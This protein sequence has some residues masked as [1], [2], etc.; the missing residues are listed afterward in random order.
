[1]TQNERFL[2]FFTRSKSHYQKRAYQCIKLLVALFTQCPLAK[3]LLETSADI[4]RKWA[5]WNI[6]NSY[7]VDD[8]GTP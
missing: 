8:G 7:F 4:K 1:V 2:T 3:Q 6:D 5:W